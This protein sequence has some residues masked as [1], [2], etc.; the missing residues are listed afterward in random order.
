M[1][2]WTA[3]G[4]PGKLQCRPP[5]L[6]GLTHLIFPRPYSLKSVMTACPRTAPRGLYSNLSDSWA[7]GVRC[8]C[9][10][11]PQMP[12]LR[13]TSGVFITTRRAFL[14]T[15]ASLTRRA[16]TALTSAA[17]RTSAAFVSA[18][19]R[20]L[21]G[22]L[23]FSGPRRAC[24]EAFASAA[25]RASSA[26]LASAACASSAAALQ[27]PLSSNHRPAAKGPPTAIPMVIE[28][29][30]RPRPAPA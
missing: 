21:L 11:P 24:S 27:P 3:F 26:A 6:G 30:W 2:S 28:A 10:S 25:R 23:C 4:R 18:A 9:R 15:F 7:V 29:P 1:K 19:R 8:F 14:A 17:C 22:S 16:S 13:V 12:F 20:G 5:L